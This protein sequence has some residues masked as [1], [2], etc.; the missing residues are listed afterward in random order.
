MDSER[1][2][3]SGVLIA[4][5]A[6]SMTSGTYLTTGHSTTTGTYLP[7]GHRDRR[8]APFVVDR[9]SPRYGRMAPIPQTAIL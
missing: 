5:N 3:T 6:I 9:L 1:A 8:P 4:L 7:T 2:T